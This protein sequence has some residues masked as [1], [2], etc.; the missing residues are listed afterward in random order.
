MGWRDWFRGKP[1]AA[2]Q[3]PLW[4][5]TCGKPHDDLPR[6]IAHSRPYEYFEV[7]KAERERRV[8]ENSDLVVIDGSR[9]FVRCVLYVPVESW[10]EPFQFGLWAALD[11]AAMAKVASL[12]NRDGRGELPMHAHLSAPPAGYPLFRMHPG[13]LQ[14]EDARTRPT[15]TL[16]PSDHPLSRDQHEGMTLA[17]YHEVLRAAVPHLFH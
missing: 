9:C 8:R 7:P 2:P 11:E 15:F 6:A 16:D 17:R 3:M 5:C 4:R 12:E 13:H 1:S 14:L 10:A